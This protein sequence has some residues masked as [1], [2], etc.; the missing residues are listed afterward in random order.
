VRKGPKAEKECK[1][2]REKE[3]SG[4]KGN[5]LVSEGGKPPGKNSGTEEKAS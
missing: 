3:E 5:L 4:S 2:L 1:N